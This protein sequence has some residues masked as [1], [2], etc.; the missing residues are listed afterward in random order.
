MISIMPRMLQQIVPYL[1]P[2]GKNANNSVT[3]TVISD[4][5]NYQIRKI[6][7]DLL[8]YRYI[9]L[10]KKSSEK[11][12][13]RSV[14]SN[15]LVA[16]A[17]RLHA[18]V[19]V[20]RGFVLPEHL[21]SEGMIA[22]SHDPHQKHAQYFITTLYE[23]DNILASARQIQATK[24][25]GFYSFPILSQANINKD[26]KSNI[27]AGKPDEYVEI[28]ALIKRQG[29]SVLAPLYLYRSMWR[30]SLQEDHNYWLM[31]CDVRLYSRL[32]LLFGEA[33]KPIG[34]VTP[35][36]GGDVIP[37]ILDVKQS[38]L[39]LGNH[40]KLV[41]NPFKKRLRQRLLMFFLGK[42]EL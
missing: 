2:S 8:A 12:F 36:L 40:T 19:Y 27:M 31:A 5:H 16:H 7:R 18:N 35:Y 32:K 24:R 22:F 21:D 14:K 1:K 15:A 29:S 17:K 20:Q 9:I 4:K 34:S 13:A 38:H 41:L 10:S 37:A 30:H 42:E 3:K 39:I 26:I 23:N 25:M 28:S 11:Y 33:I 6:I